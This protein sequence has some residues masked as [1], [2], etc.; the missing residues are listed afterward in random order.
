MEREV[1]FG[2]E[3]RGIS[4]KGDNLEGWV[5]RKSVGESRKLIQNHREWWR[6]RS[7]PSEIETSN[8][9]FEK[10]RQIDRIT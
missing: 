7:K 2:G 1:E 9:F 4:K 8:E 6:S 10:L 3:V 5:A